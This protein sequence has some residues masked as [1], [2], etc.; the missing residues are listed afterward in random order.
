MELASRK[1][2]DLGHMELKSLTR[3]AKGRVDTD[4]R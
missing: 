4:V 1:P 2:Y 3:H